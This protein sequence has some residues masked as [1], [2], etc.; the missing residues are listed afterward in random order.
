VAT[1]FDAAVMTADFAALRGLLLG[2]N[3][4]LRL[5]LLVLP[6]PERGALQALAAGWASEAP[7]VLHDGIVDDLVQRLT[8]PEAD[9]RLQVL[10]ARLITAPDALQALAETVGDAP[11]KAPAK[12]A[13]ENDAPRRS[14]AERRAAR[15]ARKQA[16]GKAGD[17]SPRL[18]CEDELLEAFS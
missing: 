16:G 5:R 14:R 12:D 11:S 1:R 8:A 3:P 9:P 7:E 10:L 4:A 6:G 18:I 13:Q 2:L 15:E 17:K